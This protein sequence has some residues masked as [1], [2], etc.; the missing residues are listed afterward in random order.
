MATL[1]T[2]LMFGAVALGIA[3]CAETATRF[4]SEAGSFIDE[5]GFGNPTMQNMMAQMCLGVGK[6]FKPGSVSDPVVVLDPASAPSQPVFYR[7]ST[8]TCQDAMNGK[9][10]EVVFR[11]YVNSAVPLPAGNDLIEVEAE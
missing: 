6:G 10:A 4:N 5:G 8:V 3:A 7:Q 9:Y 2:Y 11:E 1:N